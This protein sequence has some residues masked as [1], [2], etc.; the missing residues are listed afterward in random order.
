MADQFNHQDAQDF[1]NLTDSIIP[2]NNYLSNWNHPSLTPR[3][4]NPA[5]QQ[6]FNVFS[7][8]LGTMVPT[9]SLGSPTPVLGQNYSNTLAFQANSLQHPS[10]NSVREQEER[11]GDCL[12]FWM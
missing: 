2:S 3:P 11:V 7:P 6:G 5:F 10:Y 1:T 12:I 4:E 9:S 8:G